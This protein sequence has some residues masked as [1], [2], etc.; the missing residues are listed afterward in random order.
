MKLLLKKNAWIISLFLIG[1]SHATC[2]DDREELILAVHDYLRDS[3]PGT[4][5]AQKYGWPIG[6]WCVSNVTDFSKIFFNQTEFNED[7]SEWDTSQAKNMHGMFE[8][9]TRFN[10]P[11]DSWSVSNVEDMHSMFLDAI[12][13][14][15]DLSNWDVSNVAS[16]KHMFLGA[17]F[18]DGNVSPW[19]VSKCSDMSGMFQAAVSFNGDISEWEISEKTDMTLMFH[20]AV[21]FNQDLCSW[22]QK[23]QKPTGNNLFQGTS[24]QSEEDPDF[25]LPIHGPFCFQC[26]KQPEWKRK[27]SSYCRFGTMKLSALCIVPFLFIVLKRYLR[28]KE[29][30]DPSD[31]KL[32]EFELLHYESGSIEEIE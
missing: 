29:G 7:I 5:V 11:L 16:M 12:A 13:F 14:N 32:T 28:P 4:P 20:D 25:S 27:F 8:M 30:I 2:F 1:F 15:Q 3:S 17:R 6:Q 18:F 31:S 9:A 10:Q 26:S 19:I 23:I 22:G 24:C 21:S